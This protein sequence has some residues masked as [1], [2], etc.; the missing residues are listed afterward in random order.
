MTVAQNDVID[1]AGEDNSTGNVRLTISDHLDWNDPKNQHLLVL[2]DKF[3]TYLAFIE[4]GQLYEQFP[5]ARGKHIV[6]WVH[7]KY[8]LNT[9]AQHFY[10]HARAK[11]RDAGFEL[12]FKLAEHENEV[13][14]KP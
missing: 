10:S 4:S 9:E 1:F 13:A 6:I 7:G 2:Q 3:N 14:P 11:I 5:Q 8:P 12:V